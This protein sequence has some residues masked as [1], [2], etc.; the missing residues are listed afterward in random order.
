[1]LKP[2]FSNSV[3]FGSGNISVTV[4]LSE[5]GEAGGLSQ[6]TSSTMGG[7]GEDVGEADEEGV[8]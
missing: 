5:E 2:L 6:G 7:G 4:R 8:L 3:S 1:M